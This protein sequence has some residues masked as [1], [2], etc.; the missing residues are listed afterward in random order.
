MTYRKPRPYTKAIRENLPNAVHVFDRFHIVKMFNEV[1]DNVRCSLF[2]KIQDKD[3]KSALNGSKYILLK[4]PENLDATKKELHSL[5]DEDE[6]DAA[7]GKMLD[8]IAFMFS[9]NIPYL[10]R[11]AKSLRDHA[12]GILA[13][14]D[15]EI[16]T[17]PLEGLN[18]KI[19]NIKRMAYGF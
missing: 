3:E 4:R 8:M 17:G 7:Q 1:I 6:A 19:K 11:F 10:K 18:N 9:L 13:W 5:W 12:H 15:Y 14:F 16:S 2:R